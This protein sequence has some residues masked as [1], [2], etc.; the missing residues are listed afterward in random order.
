MAAL[1]A[2]AY[3]KAN[4]VKAP[5]FTMGDTPPY[6]RLAVYN[7]ERARGLVH[8]AEYAAA[9]AELQAQYDQQ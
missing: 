7:A 9:M 8:T 6:T 4:E 2:A 3:G 5:G 1:S